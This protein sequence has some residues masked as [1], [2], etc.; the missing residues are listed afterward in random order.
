MVTI[1]SWTMSLNWPVHVTALLPLLLPWQR[2]LTQAIWLERVCPSVC[3]RLQ[4]TIPG[5]QGRSLTQILSKSK[6]ACSYIC[7]LALR[8]TSPHLHSSGLHCYRVVLLTVVTSAHINSK[9]PPM[10][11]AQQQ[12][13]DHPTETVFPIETIT[14]IEMITCFKDF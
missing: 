2:Y 11:G 3:S 5:G 7:R 13:A 8:G 1:T 6:H 10:T 4:F 14:S 9:H 12:H